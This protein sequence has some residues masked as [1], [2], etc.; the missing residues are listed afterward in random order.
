MTNITKRIAELQ[1]IVEGSRG[2]LSPADRR[3]ILKEIDAMKE[4]L[5]W[6]E[7]QCSHLSEGSYDSETKELKFVMKNTTRYHFKTLNFTLIAGEDTKI[8]ITVADWRPR[9]T[10]EISFYHNFN[11]DWSYQTRKVIKLKNHADSVEYELF[12]RRANWKT[13]LEDGETRKMPTGYSKKQGYLVSI[14]SFC[15]TVPEYDLKAKARRL[16]GI[17]IDIFVLMANKPEL[18]AQTR[19]FM[20]VYLPTVNRVLD[21]Y[22]KAS[23]KNEAGEEIEELRRKTH[24]TLNL[25]ITAFRKLKAKMENGDKDA[26][27][28]DIDIMKK[29]MEEE[30]LV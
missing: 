10:K 12:D 22:Q 3:Q 5:T 27:S 26:T 15:E 29:F 23:A 1:R 2:E 18:R 25:A 9:K 30:G 4:I 24:E 13:G 7:Y 11:E 19:N 17:I 14:R 28:V 20:I 8:P 21:E 6:V 16:E